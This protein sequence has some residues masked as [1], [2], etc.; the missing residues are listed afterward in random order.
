MKFIEVIGIIVPT[1]A[2]I[3]G[4][5]WFIVQRALGSSVNNHRL[6]EVEKKVCNAQCD[7]HQRDIAQLGID[8]KDIKNDVIAIKSMAKKYRKQNEY[9]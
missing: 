6:E 5:V 7:I 2:A 4:G 8:L 9:Y 3:L 1:I